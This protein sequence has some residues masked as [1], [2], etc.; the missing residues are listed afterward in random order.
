MTTEDKE[1]RKY[2]RMWSFKEYRGWSPG[3]DA[4]PVAYAAMQC[5]EGESLIDMGCGTGRAGNYFADRGLSVTL[6]DFVTTAVEINYLPFV[7]QCLWDLSEELRADYT[8]CADVMEH[9]P[10]DY[11]ERTLDCIEKATLNKCFFQIATGRD[12]CGALIG[13]TLH[14][15]VELDGYW[16]DLL[17]KRFNMLEEFSIGHAYRFVGGKK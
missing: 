2:E 13:E 5:R 9:I 12:S 10:P 7:N 4:A 16:R 15:T 8:F 3:L 6:V 1:R 17:C 14:L 11:V